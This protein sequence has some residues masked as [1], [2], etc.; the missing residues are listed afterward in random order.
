MS[1]VTAQTDEAVSALIDGELSPADSEAVI[2]Q[3]TRDEALRARWTRYFAGR[4]ALAGRSAPIGAD[5]ADR[6]EARLAS[7]PVVIG[8]LARSSRRR[9]GWF[10]A[11][12]RVTGF[13]VAAS[14]GAIA[15]AGLLT[16]REAAGPQPM[17]GA[18]I[19]LEDRVTTE[20]MVQT[21]SRNSV[22]APIL[23]PSGLSTVSVPVGARAEAV[24]PALSALLE[25]YVTTHA[26]FA[27]SAQMPGLIQSGRLAG[28]RPDH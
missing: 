14:V 4:A 3:V 16:L 21:A 23:R 19:A 8:P 12:R 20:G 28:H 6:I 10:G 18:E 27:G 24:D 22:F 17:P 11:S 15:L 1:E 9:S 5:F 2:E 7:E 25:E 13:A 26:V